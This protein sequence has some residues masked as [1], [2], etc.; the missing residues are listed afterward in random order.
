MDSSNK[1][2]IIFVK[3]GEKLIPSISIDELGS[4]SENINS[5]LKS[6]EKIYSSSIQKMRLI[7]QENFTLRKKKKL[8]PARL[9]WQFGDEIFSLIGKLNVLDFRWDNL[10]ESLIRDLGT[11]DTTLERVISFR[12]YVL[13]KQLIPENLSWGTIKDSPKK[14]LNNLNKT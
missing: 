1:I 13:E 2:G 6:A 5:Q 9:M 10:Y 14:Y 12:R 7:I 11:S 3:H 4:T 8:V